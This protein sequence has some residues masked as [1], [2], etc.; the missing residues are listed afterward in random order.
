MRSAL[1]ATTGRILAVLFLAILAIPT[2]AA[3][4]WRTEVY[5]PG[6][7]T[8][9][10]AG[11]ITMVR[12][13][14]AAGQCLVRLQ[15]GVTEEEFAALLA[16]QKGEVLKAFPRYGMFL[17]SLPEG[18]T[19]VQGVAAWRAQPG[20][21]DAGP[22]L[23][24]YPLRTPNDPRYG[25]QYH[26]PRVNAPEGWD[27]TT[28]SATVTVAVVDTGTDLDHE[29]LASRLWVNS[30]EI[31]GDG[32]DNDGN[33][34]VDDVNGWD[35]YY[36]D[37]D[38][39]PHPT[40][41]VTQ[42]GAN[43]GTHCAGIIGAASDNRVG[44]TGHDWNCRIMTCKVFPDDGGGALFSTIIEG[45]EYAID[46]G[47][48]VISLSLGGGYSTM[49]NPPVQRARQNGILVVAAAGNE[50]WEFTDI[51]SSW[52][53]PVCND[54]PN[55][56]TDN[57]VLGVAA[58]DSGDIKADFSNYD[59][60]STK[61]F[62]D[63]C[64]PGVAIL[65]CYIY[66]PANGF[67]QPYDLM[68]GT[69]MSAPCVAGLASLILS[70]FPSLTPLD[71]IDQIKSTADNIDALNPTYAG[72]LG[73]GRINTAEAI[74]LDLPPGPPRSVMAVDTPRD[75][76]GSITVSWSKSVD[77]GRGRNDVREYVVYRCDN[78]KDSQGL[79]VPAGNWIQKGRVP[80][81]EF[82]TFVDTSVQDKVFYWYRVSAKDARNEAFAAPSGP[83]MARDD[84]PPPA[85]EDV[86]AADNQADEGGAISVSWSTYDPPS[87][88]AGYR[89][90][91]GQTAFSRVNQAE[92]VGEIVAAPDDTYYLDRGTTDGVNYWYAV[93][94][95]DDEGNEEQAVTP[96][97][98]VQSAPNLTLSLPA[99][100][101]MVSIGATTTAKDMATLLGVDPG[102]LKLARYDPYQSAYRTYQSNPSDSFLQQ[103]PGRAF[104]LKLDDPLLL[105][106]AGARIT[107]DPF[108]V[109][110]A[111]GWN[112]V[113][114]P[115]GH[116]L[117]W[118]NVKVAAGGTQYGLPESNQARITLD[119]AWVWDPYARAYQLV[120]E[121]ENFGT[122]NIRQNSGFW[123]KA[124][125]SC[126]LL[127]PSGAEVASV[128]GAPKTIA[129]DWK[130]RLVARCGDGADCD[131]Y[132][133]VSTEAA[134]LNRIVSPPLPMPGLELYFVN[135]GIE[136]DAAASFV[137]PAQKQ[138]W[139]ARV[140]VAALGGEPVELTWPDLSELPA[141]VRP[142][143]TDQATGKRLYLRTTASYRFTPAPGEQERAFL[144]ETQ[145][146][147]EALRVSA[148]SA[149]P[150]GPGVSIVFT[151]SAAA[152][153]DIEVLNI[154]GR[155]VRV[156]AAGRE[157]DAGTCTAQ[158]NATSDG[159]APV[160][161]GT[162]LVRVRA[163]TQDG[164]QTSSIAAVTVRR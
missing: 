108:V 47:A 98:P 49:W 56:A 25:E 78:A 118:E 114:N 154:A 134:A 101:L 73:T 117:R 26:W 71:L 62:V 7:R 132:L 42:E 45:A 44:V 125:Q 157:A 93:T 36:G 143:L 27:M 111:P 19:V 50:Y 53:S 52:L 86:S 55:P 112:M 95:Y 79:D 83:V 38:P 162:Y 87:D 72:K 31:P 29:D 21:A 64:A 41:P 39:M 70:R 160:P 34:F 164:Q 130:M 107:T 80:V 149:R 76:G 43:H 24:Y 138:R 102:H 90:Y 163:R 155:R 5:G 2:W 84:L 37:N 100:L 147:G 60:S 115:F 139:E 105:N 66:D 59:G 15:P 67:V 8:S 94:A 6:V 156:V 33:G 116:D 129:M 141:D 99:G 110:L 120:S 124:L 144:I 82:L 123:F 69:S 12:D 58:T 161:G 153:V 146:A 91:R 137:G 54:G 103:A 40:D 148:L 126:E 150:A 75:E 23:V 65:S 30:D 113:G 28:G 135:A 158:W 10:V 128:A 88:F 51:Q 9:M 16:Q 77:D 151:L 127:L 81:G 61:T 18:V 122:K 159:G 85:V 32:L 1:C 131:N 20:V 17:V 140:R 14:C 109:T 133:G 92:R 46:N 145:S 104:W 142:V 4:P 35:F 97:G 11:K 48:D 136:G 22:D 89:I 57:W 63:V 3:P 119:F 121:Y 106:L 152:S 96:V 13:E 74:G 68:G